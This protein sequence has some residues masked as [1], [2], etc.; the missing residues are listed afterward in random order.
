M[1][2]KN[3]KCTLE[4]ILVARD[5]RQKIQKN[6]LDIYKSPLISF[7]V[8]IPG[9]YKLTQL[10]VNIH[11]CGNQLILDTIK[12]KDWKIIHYNIEIKKTGVEGYYIIDCPPNLLKKAM[13]ELENKYSLGR[14]LDI[15]VI[16]TNGKILSRSMFGYEKRKCLI[17]E[18]DAVE[19]G[20]NRMHSYEILN[21]KIKDIFNE[22]LRKG[23]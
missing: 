20:R 18:K 1:F 22:F 13:I 10:S 3:E 19:C 6:L 21:K 15:D 8:N 14:V 23:V 11:D 16:D 7:M 17:C 5:K 4:E 2:E 9:P 12:A